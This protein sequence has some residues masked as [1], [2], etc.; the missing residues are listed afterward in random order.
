MAR[1][2]NQTKGTVVAG[3]VGHARTFLRRFRGRMLQSSLDGDTS[4]SQ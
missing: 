3:Q 2:G 4:G 1:R